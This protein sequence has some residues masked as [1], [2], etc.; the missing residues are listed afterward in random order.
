MFFPRPYPDELLASV[1]MRFLRYYGAEQM[2][3]PL[4]EFLPLREFTGKAT[5]SKKFDMRKELK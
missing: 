5:L 2:Q 1:V 4:R 3:D